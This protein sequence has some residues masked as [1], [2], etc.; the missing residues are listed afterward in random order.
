[1]KSRRSGDR[2]PAKWAVAAVV[3]AIAILPVIQAGASSRLGRREKPRVLRVGTFNGI[4][5]QFKSIQAAVDQARPGDWVLVGPGD[6]HERGSLDKELPAGVLIRTAGIHLRGM[7]R[8]KV[9]VDGTKKKGK[10]SCRAGSKAQFLG[11]RLGKHGHAG[12]NGVVAYK[13]SDVT[14]E[15]LTVCNYL[16]TKAGDTGNEIW[17]NGGDGSGKIGM[18]AY[19]G[20]YLTASSTYAHGFG[21][22][23]AEYGIFVS[24]ADGPGLLAHTYANNQGDA[25][26]YVG[27]CPD[28]N[29]VIDDAHGQNSALGYSGTNS[30]GHLIVQNSEFDHNKTGFTTD[31][32]NNDDKPS[33]Q[34][35]ICPGNDKGPTGSSSC[36]VFRD[37]YVHDNNDPNVPGVGSGL[38]GAAPVGTGVLIAG[39]R[40]DTVWHNRIVNNGSWGMLIV[41]SPYQGTPPPGATCQG[42]VPAGN[43]TCYYGAWASEVAHNTFEHDGYYGNPTNADIGMATQAH[44]PGNCFHDDTDKDGVTS[45]PPMI[46]GPPYDTCGQPNGGDLGPL[47]AEVLCAT[48]LLAPCPTNPAA[49][50]PRP[51]KLKLM[52]IPHEATMP[53]PCKG[54]PANPWCR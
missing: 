5:G 29:I 19:R 8:N 13:V 30:G 43:D 4:K 20:S 41:D 40:T 10:R 18:H 38:A 15:N 23:R 36:W 28:C 49:D 37:N 1:M 16:V 33:P 2:L 9:I 42:G 35:G 53:D 22:P 47:A 26:Y 27:A 39:G 6:Y 17:F 31:S 50:Y 3:G 7:N 14:I 24:N 52:P 32:E 21:T 34:D 46:E 11:P 48:Q 45:D 51:T 12:M 44:D 25:A 54:V